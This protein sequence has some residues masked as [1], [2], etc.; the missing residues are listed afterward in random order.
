[1]AAGSVITDP[2][3]GPRLR[4]VNH[5]AV[6]LP[7]SRPAIYCVTVSDSFKMGREAARV[8]I[9]TTNIAST[10]WTR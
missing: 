10:K 7:P 3:I 8:M 6:R 5:Q 4:M 9:V 1:M 2:R